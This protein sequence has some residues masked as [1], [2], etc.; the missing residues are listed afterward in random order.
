[1]AYMR[2]IY[3]CFSGEMYHD[4]TE[5][6]VKDGPRF[7]A[8]EVWVFDD[9]WLRTRHPE[10]IRDSLHLIQTPGVRGINWF[11]F[12]AFTV[13]KALERATPGDVVLFTDADTYPIHDLSVI[14]EIAKRDGIMLFKC[15]GQLHKWWCK[16]SCYE[17][18][19]ISCDPYDPKYYDVPHGCARFMAFEVN[20]T[21]KALMKEWLH[22]C[23][24]KDCT[25]FEPSPALYGPENPELHQHRCEQ[26]ILTNLAYK[27]GIRLYREAC[28]FGNSVEEDKDLFPQLF[29]Q[30]GS[31][32]WGKVRGQGSMFR[33]VD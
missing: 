12:K 28:Q 14:F 26:A 20:D 24:I 23:L 1:M 6:I 5:R 25:T 17:N 15:V 19:G 21:N 27:H 7:G 18:M 22:Y 4:W 8:D 10:H 3:A 29:E 31:H 11:A 9:Y 30:N 13:L 16:R 33:N 2:K 32:T